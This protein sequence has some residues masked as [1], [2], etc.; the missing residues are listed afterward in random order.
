MLGAILETG[1]ALALKPNRRL[2]LITQDRHDALHFDLKVTYVTRYK[3]WYVG[4]NRR[5][6]FGR[7]SALHLRKRHDFI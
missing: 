3:P 1:I 7:G 2:V 6:G 4:G 5:G